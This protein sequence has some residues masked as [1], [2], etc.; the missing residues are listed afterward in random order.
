MYLSLGSGHWLL[1]SLTLSV[2]LSI[3]KSLSSGTSTWDGSMA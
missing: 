2:M 1:I 3:V